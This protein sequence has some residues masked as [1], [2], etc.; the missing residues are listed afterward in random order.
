MSLSH[1][2]TL[3]IDWCSYDAAKYAVRHWHY[4][5]SLPCSKT[6]RLGVWEN[7]KFIGA[8]V[9][10]WGANRHLAGEYKLKMTECAE[11]CRIAL[12]KHTTPVSRIISIAVKMLKREMLGIRLLVSYADLNQ[13]HKGKIYQASN[14]FFVG[15]TGNEAGIMLNGKLTHRRTINSKYGTSDIDWLRSHLD[16]CARRYEGKPKF[17]Y[18][19]PLDDEIAERIQ[20]LSKPYPN[21]PQA[22]ESLRLEPIQERAV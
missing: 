22:K 11:L 19:L 6:A 8:V 10:A 15:E 20:P 14:W 21:A 9:F 4:S 16:P 12:D 3:R 5:R 18:L 17:K 1:K 7:D 13:G 2:P